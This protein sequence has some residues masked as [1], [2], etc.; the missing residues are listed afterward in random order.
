MHLMLDMETLGT[1]PVTAPILQISLVPFNLDEDGPLKNANDFQCFVSAQSNEG[2]PFRRRANCD[3]I[4]WWAET[5]PALLAKIMDK[6]HGI[7]LA[8]A[9]QRIVGYIQAIRNEGLTIDGIWAKGP[10]FDIS[11]I[12]SAFEQAGIPVPWDFRD[13]RC[14]RT[15]EMIGGKGFDGGTKTARELSGELHDARVDCDKQIRLVQQVWQR[16][17]V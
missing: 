3:T 14:V 4:R 12:E 2:Y 11:M 1:H 17:L 10:T 13:H 5:N 7:S 16:K 8:K 15:M 6:E 9:L